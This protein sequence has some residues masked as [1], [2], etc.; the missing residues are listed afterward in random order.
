M[1]R[2]FND[3]IFDRLHHSV[4]MLHSLHN[5]HDTVVMDRGEID[6]KFFEELNNWETLIKHFESFFLE[7]VME[8]LKAISRAAVINT[9]NSERAEE[10]IENIN[11]ILEAFDNMESEYI[12]KSQSLKNTANQFRNQLLVIKRDMEAKIKLQK[13][14]KKGLDSA[15]TGL[16]HAN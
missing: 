4:N 6:Q 7:I 15:I 1:V 16:T 2:A 5:C 3:E 9:D 8:D 14:H 10:L 13:K 12:A 11:N